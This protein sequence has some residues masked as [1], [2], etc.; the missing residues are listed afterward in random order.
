M[1][2]AT[3]QNTEVDLVVVGSGTGLAAALTAHELG[4]T[5]LVVE[6]T[7]KLGGSTAL[8]GGAFWIP[9]NTVL[10][11]DGQIDDPAR[12]RAYMEACVNGDAKPELWQA[13][14]D[15][16]ADTVDMLRRATPL[17]FMWAKGYSDYH[18]TRPGGHGLG[19][20]VESKPF[21]VNSLGAD[22]KYLRRSDLKAPIPMPITG[23]DYRQLNL[24]ARTPAT[25][26]PMAAKLVGKGVFGKVRGKD[27]TAGGTALAGG[28]IAGVM[29]AGIPVWLESS[30]GSLTTDKGRVTGAV[31]S[32]GGVDYTVTAHRGVLLAA[33]GF[34]HNMDWR[35]QYQSPSLDEWTMGSPGNTGDAIALGMKAGAAVE[36]MDQTWWFPAVAPATKGSAPSV[37]LAERSLPGSFIVNAAGERF[38]NESQDY[39]SFGQRVMQLER[40]GTPVESMW[41][42]FDQTYRNSY[43]F[44]GA[45][46]PRQKLPKVWY[47]AGI[48]HRADSAAE[49][50]RSIG[51]PEDT[52]TATFGRFNTLAAAAVDED[53]HRG[54]TSY[55]RYYGDPTVRPNANLRPLTGTLYAVRMVLA[56]LGT[57]GGLATNANA[58]VLREDGTAIEGLYASGNTSANVF[59]RSYPGAGATIGQG[60][61]FGY[62]AAKHAAAQQVS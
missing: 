25:S 28:L 41:I 34:D 5:V 48:A 8:S 44:A 13:Y 35:H 40:D 1:P 62:L 36:Q 55:D 49:L 12:Y 58:Q 45:I 2:I 56:D 21:D 10:A 59:G 52:F 47:D 24:L 43:V 20:S 42:V 4:L 3:P 30:I 53:F 33:G 54:A 7:D 11:Q 16:G 46:F 19:R 51:L 39:M 60:L 15:N 38:T 22:V 29:K 6:K 37:M 61:V 23:A 14:A 31:V 17:T 57:C 50:A 18:P 26:L 27:F 32:H 9:G